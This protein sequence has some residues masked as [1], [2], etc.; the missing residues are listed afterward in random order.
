LEA[1]FLEAERIVSD[2][3]PSET[4]FAGRASENDPFQSSALAENRNADAGDN[5]S[6]WVGY[7]A[8][9]SRKLGLRP[10]TDGKEGCQSC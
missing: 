3:Q 2:W 8:R 5:G 6:T 7:G 4:E 1:W 10:C 9:N